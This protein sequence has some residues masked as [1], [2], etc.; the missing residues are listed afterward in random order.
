MSSCTRPPT[1]RMLSAA[2]AALSGAVPSAG[3]STGSRSLSRLAHL[4]RPRSARRVRSVRRFGLSSALLR[5]WEGGTRS[6]SLAAPRQAF[7]PRRV[8]P[9]CRRRAAT[10]CRRSSRGFRPAARLVARAHAAQRRARAL[11]RAFAQ[12]GAARGACGGARGRA[13]GACCGGA[14]VF[15]G[16]EHEG[17]LSAPVG[18][19]RLR[20]AAGEHLAISG[21]QR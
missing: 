2:S 4:Q 7:A 19:G 3:R 8:E 18:L 13:R 20:D 15:E 14:V 6:M 12:D 11:A 10:R 5:S 17:R 1:C 21:D 16:G 9:R